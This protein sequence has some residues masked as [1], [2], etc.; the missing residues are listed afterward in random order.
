M[1][2]YK[3]LHNTNMIKAHSEWRQNQLD[4]LYPLKLYHFPYYRNNPKYWDQQ[5]LWNSV[6]PDQM[7]QNMVSD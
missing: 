5:V 6:D 3:I 2:W 1:E 4:K 7:L